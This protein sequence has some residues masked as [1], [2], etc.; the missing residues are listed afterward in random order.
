MSNL[1]KFTIYPHYYCI[2]FYLFKVFENLSVF[3]LIEY[4]IDV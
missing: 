1:H 4:N 2:Y 3:N